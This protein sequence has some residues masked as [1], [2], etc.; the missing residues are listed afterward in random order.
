MHRCPRLERLGPILE[1]RQGHLQRQ[2]Y[3]LEVERSPIE[4]HP[5]LIGRFRILA[6]RSP[7]LGM[8]AGSWGAALGLRSANSGLGGHLNQAG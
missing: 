8:A 6:L 5:G 4:C 1:L 2:L 7:P 3:E